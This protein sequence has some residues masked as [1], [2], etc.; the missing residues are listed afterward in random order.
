[1][2]MK[3]YILDRWEEYFDRYRG[4]CPVCHGKNTFTASKDFNKIVY[5]CY[6]NK[7]NVKGSFTFALDSDAI[8][9]FIM[10]TKESHGGTSSYH[11]NNLKLPSETNFPIIP[12]MPSEFCENSEIHTPA[13]AFCGRWMIDPEDVYVDPTEGRV[14]FPIL[15]DLGRVVDAVGRTT[16]NKIPKWKRYGNSDMPYVCGYGMD[17]LNVCIVVED[18]I[19][20]YI[21]HQYTGATGVAL[22]GTTLTEGYKQYLDRYA[23]IIVALD[24]D[25]LPKQLQITKE[26]RV[27]YKPV[28]AIRLHDDLKYG[29]DNDIDRINQML[30]RGW[31]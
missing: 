3:D 21:V 24:R 16:T 8:V 31:S 2:N 28:M 22:L 13:N 14:V 7:C 18:A 19:S 27:G 1:M 4:D 23:K 30:S 6:A 11:I 9:E 17:A 26:L 20:A 12:I 5:N 25:A 15:D 10:D 29:L